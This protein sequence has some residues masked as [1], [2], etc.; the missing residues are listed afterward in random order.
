MSKNVGTPVVPKK[1]LAW[2]RLQKRRNTCITY[3]ER[4]KIN[5]NVHHN[6]KKSEVF[7]KFEWMNEQTN[8]RTKNNIIER[9]D[10]RTT[11]QSVEAVLL[12]KRAKNRKFD[13]VKETF[14]H[15]CTI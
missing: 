7:L 10:G 5:L 15:L 12:Q 11:D 13:E 14:K 2:C 6:F 1:G 4:T 3:N 8:E 9:K